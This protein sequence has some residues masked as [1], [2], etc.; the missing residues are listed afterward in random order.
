M[1]GH[2]WRFAAHDPLATGL[3]EVLEGSY[4]GWL[5][6]LSYGVAVLAAF[7][8][9]AIED[10]MRAAPR[11]RLVFMSWL[12]AGAAAMG[13]GIWAMHFIGMLAFGLLVPVSYDIWVTLAS[14]VPSLVGSGVALFIL[15]RESIGW[16]AVLVGILVVFSLGVAL[17]GTVVHERLTGASASLAEGGVPPAIDLEGRRCNGD[18]GALEPTSVS[19]HAPSTRLASPCWASSTMCSTSRRWRRRAMSSTCSPEPPKEKPSIS[20]FR[21]PTARPPVPKPSTC[22]PVSV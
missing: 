16:M 1:H 10:S 12:V 14:V 8:A 2:S 19:S 9:L 11:V 22:G 17:A 5:V 15:S 20:C 7:A 6:G 21:S 4:D 3:G 13:T 18:V